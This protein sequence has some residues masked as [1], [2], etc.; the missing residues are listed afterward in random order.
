M[1]VNDLSFDIRAGEI[2]GLIGPNGAGKSTT[3]ALITGAL[4]LTA[5]DIVF[6]GASIG[7]RPPYGIARLRHRRARSSTCSCCRG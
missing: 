7:G 5:G 1:A 3:F 2:L 6:R 4:P